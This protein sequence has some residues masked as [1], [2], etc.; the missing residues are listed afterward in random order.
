MGVTIQTRKGKWGHAGYGSHQE[1]E[2]YGAYDAEE[3]DAE[4]SSW[5]NA[6]RAWGRRS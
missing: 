1:E 5:S 6:A 4:G 3:D 2:E